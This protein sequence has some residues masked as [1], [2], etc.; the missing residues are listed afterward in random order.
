MYVDRNCFFQHKYIYQ[1][2]NL[3]FKIVVCLKVSELILMKVL[4]TS[5]GR[6]FA[7]DSTTW[8]INPDIRDSAPG[9]YDPRQG[10]R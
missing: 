5:Y 4:P 10:P 8:V 6:F 7:E 9:Y 3:Q 2:I 1:E